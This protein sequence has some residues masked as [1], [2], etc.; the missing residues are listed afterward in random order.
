MQKKLRT[1]VIQLEDTLAQVRKEYEMLRI[2]FEQNLAA[3]EQAGEPVFPLWG[4]QSACPGNQS[5]CSHYQ[6]MAFPSYFKIFVSWPQG[7]GTNWCPWCCY[8]L[9]E[10]YFLVFFL[11]PRKL[12]SPCH[13]QAGGKA[14]VI[15]CVDSHLN[16]SFI[17]LG[18]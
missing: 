18:F 8:L 15:F 3:N 16:H 4:A 10:F 17:L 2:E 14:P 5:C 6:E 1:E 12:I 11:P 13:V 7:E 9:S